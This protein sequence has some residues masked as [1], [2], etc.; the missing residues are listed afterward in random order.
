MKK[1]LVNLLLAIV[2]LGGL[3]RLSIEFEGAQ[4][5]AI[6]QFARISMTQ[7][8]KGLPNP[9]SLRVFVCGSASPLGTSDRAQACI[10]VL[11]PNHFYIIDSGA[12]STA[13]VTRAGLPYERLRGIFIT[14]FH[15]DHIA[16]IYELN[17]MSWV[18]GRPE[19][20]IVYGP[21]GVRKITNGINAT[22]DFDQEYRTTHHGE[23]LLNPAL[24]KLTS[25]TIKPGVVLE[26]GD[27]TITAYIADHAPI[28]PAVGYRFDYR[29]R[30]VVISGDSNV[31]AET[32]LIANGV[33]LLLHDAL[34]V[35][36]ITSGAKAAKAAG[37]DRLSTIMTDVLDYHASTDSLIELAGNLEVGMIA[38]YH[39]VPSPGNIVM[40]KVFERNLPENFLVARDGDW[41]ELPVDSD[42]IRVV[43]R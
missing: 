19:P 33:D 1:F 13:N 42:E 20:L 43:R 22:Y 11:T 30:S 17:L 12:G 23:Q 34:A 16:E 6:E 14:H 36:L 25:Q 27:L 28:E 3:L 39:L 15:S 32:L 40:E 5:T 24:G 4:D 2:V 21:R 37:L 26:D 7:A 35:P 31:T 9:D 38:F 10:A 29:G 8:A 18:R 41:F